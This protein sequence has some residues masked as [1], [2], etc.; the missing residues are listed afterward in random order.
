MARACQKPKATAGLS[1]CCYGLGAAIS[2]EEETTRNVLA[3]T[4]EKERATKA[5]TREKMV[6][7]LPM[8][9]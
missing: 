7:E 4:W 6:E 2:H 5:M 9:P 8:M 1:Y 3:T